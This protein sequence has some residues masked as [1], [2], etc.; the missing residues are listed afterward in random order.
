MAVIHRK[1]GYPGISAMTGFTYRGT[2]Y[3]I[4][5]F[6][7]RTDAVMTV[8]TSTDNLT[9]IHGINWHPGV[10]IMTSIAEIAALDVVSGF[11]SRIRTVVA[12]LARLTVHRIMVEA[13]Q[14]I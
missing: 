2:S 7:R 6:S 10:G 13:D 1:H 9:V 3:V 5:G 11:T 8:A 14:P 4:N 12:L